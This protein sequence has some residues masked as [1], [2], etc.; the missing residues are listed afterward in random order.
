MSYSAARKIE[1]LLD[2]I[3]NE[4]L[5]VELPRS[6]NAVNISHTPF[7]KAV[8]IAN[9]KSPPVTPIGH[10]YGKSPS[11]T[12]SSIRKSV[13]VSKTLNKLLSKASFSLKSS[14]HLLSP[15]LIRSPS[16]SLHL[17]DPNTSLSP[18]SSSRSSYANSSNTYWPWSREVFL[19]RLSTYQYRNWGIDASE[20]PNISAMACARHGWVAKTTT[21]LSCKNTVQCVTCKQSFVLNLGKDAFVENCSIQHAMAAKYESMLSTQHR[22][23]CPWKGRACSDLNQIYTLPMMIPIQSHEFRVRYHSFGNQ[24]SALKEATLV[25]IGLPGSPDA[26]LIEQFLNGMKMQ[27]GDPNY[28]NVEFKVLLLS[29]LGWSL[30]SSD[31]VPTKS[32]GPL[33]GCDYCFRK[34]LLNS[35]NKESLDLVGEHRDYCPFVSPAT[36]WRALA[37]LLTPGIIK[38]ATVP[39]K[40]DNAEGLVVDGD[41]ERTLKLKRLSK[42]Y[43]SHK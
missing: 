21:S 2:S 24:R 10:C 15:K 14:G 28:S 22:D 40:K 17:I 27:T 35:K 43:F 12:P 42:V 41:L 18:S 33:I 26:V 4:D 36:G 32:M 31:S 19:Q 8:N 6:D 29:L 39:D 7:K 20:Y 23:N 13:G 30:V 25:P 11:I 3:T 9:L 5:S 16:G 1:N 37:K 38:S 34:V